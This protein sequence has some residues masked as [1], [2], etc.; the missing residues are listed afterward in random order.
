[1]IVT[2][3]GS[4]YLENSTKLDAKLGVWAVLSSLFIIFLWLLKLEKTKIKFD[5]I[6][7]VIY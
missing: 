4:C 2:N 6:V 5:F 3:L 7:M 1:M